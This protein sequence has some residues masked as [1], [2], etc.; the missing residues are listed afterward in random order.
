MADFRPRYLVLHDYGT[1][2]DPGYSLSK[3]ANNPYHALVYPDGTV[4]YRNPDNPYGVTAPH[5]YRLNDQSVGL[6]Y[7]G[8]VGG[9]PTEAGL[10]AIRVEYD[11]IKALY[12]GIEALS[13]GEAYQRTR[14]TDQQASR[15]GRGLDEASWRSTLL[16]PKPEPQVMAGGITTSR[17]PDIIAPAIDQPRP[18]AERAMTFG[19]PKPAPTLTAGPTPAQRPNVLA[20]SRYDDGTPGGTMAPTPQLVSGPDPAQR[21]SR[22]LAAAPPPPPPVT[23]QP[24]MQPTAAQ[25]GA[26]AASSMPKPM[27]L[28]GPKPMGTPTANA[29]T[30]PTYPTWNS[31][32]GMPGIDWGAS[33]PM[34]M[35]KLFGGLFG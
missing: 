1:P 23:P 33:Q 27:A 11:K 31:D 17:V 2:S 14:G 30:S 18:M 22:S 4:R 9:Q 24:A 26:V 32:L 16:Q 35:G 3:T 6:S 25:P 20:G 19:V 5:A 29:L 13:H 8:P 12:P 34:K 28:G 7:A 15:D 21:P 10:N